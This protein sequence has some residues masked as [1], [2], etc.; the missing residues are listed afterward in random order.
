MIQQEIF[1]IGKRQFIRTY[2]DQGRYVVRDNIEYE[3]AQDPSEFN[4][5]YT[6]GD[7]ISTEENNEEVSIIDS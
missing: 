4:R 1:Y 6:E 3:E 7:L 2:S 5:K